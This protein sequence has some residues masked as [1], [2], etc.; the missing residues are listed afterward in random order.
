VGDRLKVLVVDDS[1]VIR[2]II[3][4][5][6]SSDA[7]LELVGNAA[8]GRIALERI[9]QLNPDLVTLDVEMPD[10]D[11][12]TALR[13][14]RQVR[15]MLPV[16]MFSSLTE[17]GAR[18]TI[19]ALTAGAS[20]YVCKP[21]VS[22]GGGPEAALRQV[23]QELL[24]KLRVLGARARA[25]RASAPTLILSPIVTTAPAAPPPVAAPAPR[26][27]EAKAEILVIGVS[28]GGPGALG[29]LLP[30]IPG[31]FPLP[32][33][34]TQHMPPLFTKL[35]AE[36]L[37]EN[38]RL[39]VEEARQG[40][41]LEPGLVLIA[42]GDFH[43]VVRRQTGQAVVSLSQGP[44]ENGCRPAVDPMFRSAAEQYGPGVL[45]FVLTGM[46]TDGSRGAASIKEKGGRV[47]VQDEAS[48]VVWSMPGAVYR[49]GLAER[50]A[51]LK[52][53]ADALDRLIKGEA[54]MG[55]PTSA[56]NRSA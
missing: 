47:W 5:A 7:E 42:P 35:L 40:R 43:M 26:M 24:P 49:A 25:R 54:L 55:S 32:I 10:M 39:R 13:A 18:T 3:G 46:G 51:N 1:A 36:R 53:L 29:D 30:R 15:P 31:T 14:I 48:A 50:V 19:E 34:I 9:E 56:R 52:D 37:A 22:A 38:C 16:V 28:T 4:E 2:R 12:L 23:K 8:N 6:V 20:D 33:L 44:Q 11:G 17:R 41:P 45:A 27:R 21:K